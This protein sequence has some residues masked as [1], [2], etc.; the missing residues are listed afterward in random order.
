MKSKLLLLL[1]IPFLS[2]GQV[3][4]EDKKAIDVYALDVC[5]CVSDLIQELHPKTVEAI[6]YMVENGQE[7]LPAYLEKVLLDMSDEDKQAF[8]GSFQKMQDPEF[9]AKIE[10]CDNTATLGKTLKKEI[11][12]TKTESHKYLMSFLSKEDSCKLLKVFYDIGT[13]QN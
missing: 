5:G 1:L 13:N 4:E 9:G 11:D 12:D 3:S 10:K 6:F 7:K 2:F 8:M